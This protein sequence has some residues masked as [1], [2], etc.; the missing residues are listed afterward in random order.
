M[1]DAI[2]IVHI[3]TNVE[4]ARIRARCNCAGV[5]NGFM[6]PAPS[7]STPNSQSSFAA[8]FSKRLEPVHSYNLILD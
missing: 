4:W 5:S 1:D 8:C 6:Q 2:Y 3:F 7:S